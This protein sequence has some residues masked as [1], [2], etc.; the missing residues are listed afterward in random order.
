[1]AYTAREFV[2]WRY[3]SDDG[4]K[5]YAYR[6]DKAI[7]DQVNGSSVPYV[8]GQLADN[9][10]NNPPRSFRPRVALMWNS[11]NKLARRIVC[12]SHDSLLYV[13]TQTTLNIRAGTSG[14]SFSFTRYAHEGERMRKN[15]A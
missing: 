2:V 15:R 13:G 8:G 14:E 9:T 10:E 11:A 1:M 6:V 4:A 7:T 12:Y 3:T 5:T